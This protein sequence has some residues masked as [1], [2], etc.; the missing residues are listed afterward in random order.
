MT[1][2]VSLTSIPGFR[3]VSAEDAAVLS[4]IAKVDTRQKGDA[5]VL[6]GE[7]VS[8]I[9]IVA[10]GKVGVFPAGV[11]KPIAELGPGECFGEMSFVESSRASAT[12]RAVQ[13][14]TRLIRLRQDDLAL[15][16]QNN[17]GLGSAI[18][19]GIALTLSQKLRATTARIAEELAEGRR[20]LEK[21]SAAED[22]V[23]IDLHTLPKEVVRQ[24]DAIK[25]GL[26]GVLKTLENLSTKF[27]ERSGTLSQAV[28]DLSVTS[29]QCDQFFLN[30]SRNVAALTLF[31]EKM[32]EFINNSA[33]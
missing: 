15:L 13:N 26:E 10:E 1:L 17:A 21:F 5:I 20:M 32:E 28:Q 2:K 23:P 18:F 30:L 6:S 22:D 8:A 24:H 3:F 14:D 7:H 9:F 33:V 16:S 27:P 31:L 25:E 29:K 12:I 19:R 11:A 4:S